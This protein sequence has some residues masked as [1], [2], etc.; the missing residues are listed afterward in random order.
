MTLAES[1]LDLLHRRPGRRRSPDVHRSPDGRSNGEPAATIRAVARAYRIKNGAR[2]DQALNEHYGTTIGR[3]RLED[4]IT[5]TQFNTAGRY[6]EC[7]AHNAR[8]LGIP[9][10]HARSAALLMAGQGQSCAP[11]PDP[12]WVTMIKGRFRDCRRALLDCGR[13]LLVGSEVNRI[14]YGVVIDDWPFGMVM[15]RERANLRCG[16]NALGRVLK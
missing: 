5:E 3:L 15:D 13:D 9:F 11:D 1:A 4:A 2:E 6:A 14:V 7:V 10:P 12:E 8:L 16:L